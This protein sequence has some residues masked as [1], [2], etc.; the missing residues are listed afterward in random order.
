MEKNGLA[1]FVDVR[2]LD[3][4]NMIRQA[5]EH[6]RDL[7]PAPM[8]ITGSQAYMHIHMHLPTHEKG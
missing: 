3:L 6:H 5:E 2:A 7:G 1:F 4:A 8:E